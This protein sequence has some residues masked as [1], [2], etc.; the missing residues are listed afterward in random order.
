LKQVQTNGK[1]WIREGLALNGTF[2]YSGLNKAD[3][4]ASN[5]CV[6][7]GYFYFDYKDK[8]GEISAIRLGV[9]GWHNVENAVVCIAIARHLKI[10][11]RAIVEALANF[12]GVKR[13]FDFVVRDKDHV[14]IDDYAHHPEELR[15]LIK[16][17]R[18]LYPDQHLTFVF[19]PHLFSRTRDFVEGFAEVLSQVDTLI[20]MDIYPA[21]EVPIVGVDA[22]WLLSKINLLDKHV[23]SEAEVIKF[24][25]AKRPSFLV[26]A[27]AG[28][29]DRLVEPL[30]N[31]LTHA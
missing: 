27:G 12:K 8:N 17:L 20:L 29:I 11:D 28:N 14:Y 24:V 16:S 7:N 25:E 6:E 31:I 22:A 4:Y 21:R 30:Q 26:T 23:M 2:T 19:Q 13:R 10:D 15:A 1:T 3:A 18:T 5:V 9:A